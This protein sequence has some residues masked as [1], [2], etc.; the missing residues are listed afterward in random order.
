VIAFISLIPAPPGPLKNASM[1]L[2]IVLFGASLVYCIRHFLLYK[3]CP[4]STCKHS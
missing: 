4:L 1:G 3:K 2:V